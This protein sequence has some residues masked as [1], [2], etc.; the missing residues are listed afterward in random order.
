MFGDK[1]FSPVKFE[2]VNENKVDK[3]RSKEGKNEIHEE[4]NTR[5]HHR[6]VR[7]KPVG[8]DRSNKSN[9]T[10]ACACRS[11]LQIEKPREHAANEAIEQERNIENRIPDPIWHEHFHRSCEHRQRNTDL[12]DAHGSHNEGHGA[13]GDADVCCSTCQTGEPH[14]DS[15]RDGRHRGDDDERERHGQQ[16]TH[17]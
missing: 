6:S 17:E 2:A 15:Y 1:E 14:G 5:A 13:G 8:V 16:D 9:K 4:K 7:H 12:V 3:I 10:E 11:T